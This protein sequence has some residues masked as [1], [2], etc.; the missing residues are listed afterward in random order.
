LTNLLYMTRLESRSVELRKEWQPVEEVIGSALTRL[1]P[2]LRERRVV[3]HLADGVTSAPFDG[4]LIEQ[5]LINL[6]E[7]AL[8]YTPVESPIEISAFETD[9]SV[10][11]EVADRGPGVPVGQ[12]EKI[13]EQFYRSAR[14]KGDGGVGL[15]L[16]ISNAILRAH[17]GRIWVEHRSG[18]GAA[19]RFELPREGAGPRIGEAGRLP[20]LA[21]DRARADEP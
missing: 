14:T 13:F 2:M 20:E 5:V 6:I 19:F 10:T 15:G 11:I 9:T 21:S 18:G 7:N 17:G 8:R 1:E 12:E 4:V 3:T 16:T